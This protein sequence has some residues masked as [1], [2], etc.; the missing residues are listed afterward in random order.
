MVPEL[1]AA[2]R[3]MGLKIARNAPEVSRVVFRK[4]RDSNGVEVQDPTSRQVFLEAHVGRVIPAC[5]PSATG[6][7]K[8][9]RC[10]VSQ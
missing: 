1:Y 5:V 6:H 9:M 2:I 4:D 10:I 3:A 7:N 8:L